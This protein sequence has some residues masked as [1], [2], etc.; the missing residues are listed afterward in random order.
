M[1]KVI[2]EQELQD[3]ITLKVLESDESALEDILHHY[4]PKIECAL[5]RKYHGLL[6]NSDM[7]DVLSMAIMRFWDAREKYDDKKSSIRSYLYRIADNVAKDILKHGW[8]KARRMERIV[9]QDFIEQSLKKEKHL[10]QP[11]S[12]DKNPTKPKEIEA[13]NKVLASL[14]KVKREI[15]MADA[16]TDD[17]ADS[18]ELGER[19]GGYPAATIRQYRMRARIALQKGMKKLGFNI[20]ES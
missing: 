11:V 14:S 13:I 19:L 3:E 1:D 10:N 4:A 12:D 16:M 17:V 18:A 6:S 5:A 9:E 2:S 20:P 7:E 8:H 15:L